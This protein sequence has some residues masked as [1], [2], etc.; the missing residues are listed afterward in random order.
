MRLHQITETLN[1]P[2]PYRYEKSFDYHQ[3]TATT[4][5]GSLLQIIFTQTN[6]GGRVI[7]YKDEQ[8]VTRLKRSPQTWHLDFGRNDSDDVTGEGDAFRI[9]ATVKAA[10]IEFLRQDNIDVG[11]LVINAKASDGDGRLKLY[12]RFAKM[13]ASKMNYDLSV[14]NIND[15]EQEFASYILDRNEN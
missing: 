11:R 5:D 4:E 13:I 14:K 6:P 9:F 8:G 2:Y 15:G 3:A 12:H 7:R 10:L 1:Q